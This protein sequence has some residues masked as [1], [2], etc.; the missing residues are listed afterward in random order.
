LLSGKKWLWPISICHRLQFCRF[1][2]EVIDQQTHHPTR[3]LHRCIG[4]IFARMLGAHVHQ[5]AVNGLAP[6][7]EHG[8]SQ[9]RCT[10]HFRIVCY[11]T[12]A[13]SIT[14][15]FFFYDAEWVFTCMHKLERMDA[16]FL[17]RQNHKNNDDSKL[18]FCSR[19]FS[20]EPP[21]ISSSIRHPQITPKPQHS[22][23][24]TL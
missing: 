13:Q 14:T 5:F 12:D 6:K 9:L 1:S 11:S 7:S 19:T 21:A 23:S 17:D 16:G 22:V 20:W 2:G 3:G 10:F 4:S 18:L 15:R 24:K 8:Q